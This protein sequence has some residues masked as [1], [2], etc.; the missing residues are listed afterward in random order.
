MRNPEEHL[1]E[2]ITLAD[3]VR[4]FKRRWTVIA[5]ITLAVVVVMAAY[6]FILVQERYESSA[7][8]IVSP[9]FISQRLPSLSSMD[10]PGYLQL[11]FAD[12]VIDATQTRLREKGI[13]A[14]D[15]VLLR[16]VHLNR[17]M[18]PRREGEVTAIIVLTARAETPEK[19]AAIAAEWS[20]ALRSADLA[21]QIGV[22]EYL[23]DNLQSEAGKAGT[24]LSD[25][26]LQ[27]AEMVKE[28]NQRMEQIQA[29]WM[30]NLLKLQRAEAE[31][32]SAYRHEVLEGMQRDAN[33]LL[34]PE[35]ATSAE[36]IAFQSALAQVVSRRWA[37]AATPELLTLA[38]GG[39]LSL[40]ADL[41]EQTS[42]RDLM[43]QQPN[44]A[45]QEVLLE[46]IR[47][48]D[49]LLQRAGDRVEEVSQFLL[50]VAQT[51]SVHAAEFRTL[52]RARELKEV[53]LTRQRDHQ[54]SEYQAA[55]KVDY[56]RLSHL[57]SD[58][59]AS[60]LKWSE[61]LIRVSQ[62]ASMGDLQKVREISGAKAAQRPVS[63]NRSLKLGLALLAGL[64]LGLVVAVVLEVDQDRA[65]ST[66]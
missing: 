10:A 20:D 26:E 33:A 65:A 18:A 19:A 64:L 43:T 41:K 35:T 3:V 34:P 62:I 24:I 32:T 28:D 55:R 12:S 44:P 57:L 48:E 29:E 23:A 39:D 45:Y 36:R 47:A 61:D 8:V 66:S 49:Q 15:E 40:V 46:V 63:Q 50:S 5:G 1:S 51:S 21:T 17:E 42:L 37:L 27:R 52:A 31:R 2:E 11:A 54:W 56:Q 9:T 14:S 16:D 6:Q 60:Y 30:S 59:E 7:M 22:L 58:A 53:R 13:L 4:F 38:I 25:L